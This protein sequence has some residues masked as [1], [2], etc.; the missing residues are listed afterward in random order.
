MAAA[1]AAA[2]IYY[3]SFATPK[4]SSAAPLDEAVPN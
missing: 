1:R 4:R 3:S 2:H